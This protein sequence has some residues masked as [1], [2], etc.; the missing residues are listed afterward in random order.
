MSI[1]YYDEE[2][3]RSLNLLKDEETLTDEYEDAV[4]KGDD[5]QRY[6]SRGM[7]VLSDSQKAATE[8]IERLTAENG[9]LNTATYKI[10]AFTP[11]LKERKCQ[12]RAQITKMQSK[13]KSPPLDYFQI[14]D[15]LTTLAGCSMNP[16]SALN[17]IKKGVDIWKSTQD[18]KDE[19]YKRD[20]QRI[21]RRRD[22]DL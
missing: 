22:L 14:L 18:Y 11:Q 10:G 5:L 8:R 20:K 15:A 16:L 6:V 2:L 17:A 1:H 4:K 7:T 13:F 21:H 3:D 19:K 9:P 12:I